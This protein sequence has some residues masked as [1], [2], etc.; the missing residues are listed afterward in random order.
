MD[1]ISRENNSMLPIGGIV[2]GV[3]GLLL[4]GIALLQI[5]KV[6]KT[7][8]DHQ[9]KV[10]LV[11]GVSSKADAAAG[12]AE[13]ARKQVT[14]LNASTQRAVNEI[15]AEIGRINGNIGKLEEATKKPV[16]AVDP[17]TGKAGPKAPAT[18]G[19]GE[20]IVKVGDTTGTKIAKNL[21]VSVADLVAVNPSVN[22]SKL[23]VGDKLKVPSKK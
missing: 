16:P 4:G 18:A 9:T 11:D 21:G 12:V 19:P 17:K 22:F 3:I 13:S 6:N 5:S 23:K 10:D 20:Y 1:T 15:A 14:D 7:L 2:V 8:A